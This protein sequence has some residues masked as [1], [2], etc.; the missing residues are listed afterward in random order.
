M[1]SRIFFRIRLWLALSAAIALILI[2]FSSRYY[3]VAEHNDELLFAWTV[4]M[5]ERF[6]VE[7]V[8]SL[9]LSLIVDVF[10][11]T[12]DGF[13][14]QE[15]RFTSL[16]AGAPLTADFPGSEMLHENGIFRLVNIDFPM[17]SFSIL[18]SEIPNHRISLGDNEA[19]LLELVGSGQSV[20]LDVR[21]LSV[22]SQLVSN[23]M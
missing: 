18:T 7:F 23:V 5:G 8:H 3:L 21:R 14:L 1:K 13:T 12:A 20:R 9:N 22:L 10:E 4:G 6:E 2:M 16:G 15:S 11:I 19:F 17:P